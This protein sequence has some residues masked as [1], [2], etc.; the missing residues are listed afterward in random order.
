MGAV[1]LEK[2][3]TLD[4]CDDVLTDD[5]INILKK[6]K[7]NS[8]CCRVAHNGAIDPHDWILPFPVRIASSIRRL[9]S[10]THRIGAKYDRIDVNPR[11]CRS[12]G[13]P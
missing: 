3:Y 2:Y 13:M 10:G 6:L 7:I 1:M 4:G 11:Y 9:N 12:F 5:N 8:T